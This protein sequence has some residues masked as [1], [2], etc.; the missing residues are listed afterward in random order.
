MN[1]LNLYESDESIFKVEIS[2]II[3]DN[4]KRKYLSVLLKNLHIYKILHI[5]HG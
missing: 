5:A 1:S 3:I 2:C 4:D